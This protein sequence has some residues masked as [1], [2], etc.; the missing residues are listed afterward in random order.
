MKTFTFS[1]KYRRS[2]EF[3]YEVTVTSEDISR[4]KA[5]GWPP[6]YIASHPHLAECELSMEEIEVMNEE[7]IRE[8]MMESKRWLDEIALDSI[9]EEPSDVYDDKADDDFEIVINKDG[10]E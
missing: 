1:G 5:W 6:E 7:Q 9:N 2:Q 8:H 10:A 4:K 3:D